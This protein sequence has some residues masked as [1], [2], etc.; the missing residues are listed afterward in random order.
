MWRH[1]RTNPNQFC[2]G[3]DSNRSNLQK[4]SEK[5]YRKASKRGAS[6]ALFIEA[7]VEDIPCE[8]EGLAEIIQIQFP[9]GS[10]LQSVATGDIKIL[11]NLNRICQSNALMKVIISMDPV[12]DSA[13][14]KRLEIPA[15]DLDY[16]RNVLVHKYKNAGFEI[17]EAK[18]MTAQEYSTLQSSWAKRIHQNRQRLPISLLA[19]ARK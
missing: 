15:F 6:N 18:V 13:E 19:R 3:I 4:I 7:S 5:I 16:V 14:L 8:L 12:R 9:W 17:F 1:A 10:L 2:I 11:S